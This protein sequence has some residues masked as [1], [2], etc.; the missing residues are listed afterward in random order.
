MYREQI[1]TNKMY[2]LTYYYHDNNN[3]NNFYFKNDS[4][5]CRI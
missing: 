4:L 5:I 2:H 1:N 3:N